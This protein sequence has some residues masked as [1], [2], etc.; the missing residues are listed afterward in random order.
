MTEPPPQKKPKCRGNERDIC[1][2]PL[3]SIAIC[4]SMHAHTT[5][6]SY[7]TTEGHSL[8]CWVNI[9]SWILPRLRYYVHFSNE[10]NSRWLVR[11]LGCKAMIIGRLGGVFCFVLFCFKDIHLYLKKKPYLT[12]HCGIALGY[13]MVFVKGNRSFTSKQNLAVACEL[14]KISSS[15]CDLPT[16]E[17]FHAEIANLFQHR[18]QN[19]N[20]RGIKALMKPWNE[21]LRVSHLPPIYPARISNAKY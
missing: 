2:W 21:N 20:D 18:L 15:C 16:V 17:F 4:I 12:K 6:R 1:C 10:A 19:P 13:R 3:T 5:R 14:Q 8:L 7:S 9:L 11:W